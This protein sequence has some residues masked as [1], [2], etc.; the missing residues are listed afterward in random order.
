MDVIKVGFIGSGNM[1]SALAAAA[2][3]AE[4]VRVYTADKDAE[5]AKALAERTGGEMA[6]N[7]YIAANCDYIFLGVKPQVMGDMLA[8]IGE[9]LRARKSRFV[10]VTM[11]AG[12]KIEK[13]KAMA[14]TEAPV[15]RI[16]PN[17]PAS[18]GCG[19]ILYSIGEG[20]TGA[21]EEVFCRILSK[22]GE[23]SLLP[24]KLIDA[25][26][27]V[28]GCGPAFVYMFIDAMARAGAEAG[29][30][31]E[32]ALRLAAVTTM[33]AAEM[34][35][36]THQDPVKL[37][38]DVCSPGGSTIEG[39]KVLQEKDIDKVV[40]EAVAASFKRTVELGK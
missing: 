26:C 25:G 29:L 5:K 38:T 14:G 36:K 27:A 10:L 1:G 23:L 21:E 20:V 32:Q 34:I 28:S 33:G 2:A 39:V 35:L 4:N 40:G 3:G 37:R 15:I 6:E 18:I 7:E 9:T 19:M 13:I 17:T 16:M 31:E 22:A 8:E 30:E 11:A 24:E 12:L